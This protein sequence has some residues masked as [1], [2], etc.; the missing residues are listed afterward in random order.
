MINCAT[1]CCTNAGAARSRPM[2]C[3]PLRAS[4]SAIG[5]TM[6]CGEARLLGVRRGVPFGCLGR[7]LMSSCPGLPK[8]SDLRARRPPGRQVSGRLAQFRRCDAFRASVAT[9]QGRAQL[10]Q[11]GHNVLKDQ[12]S[13]YDFSVLCMPG[14][15]ARVNGDLHIDNAIV[16]APRPPQARDGHGGSCRAAAAGASVSEICGQRGREDGAGEQDP[17]LALRAG[18]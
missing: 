18:C 17:G 12:T 13:A 9:I 2:A 15:H 7:T 14:R 11:C 1:A 4:E 3:G 6:P 10:R 16:P 5:M 8:P